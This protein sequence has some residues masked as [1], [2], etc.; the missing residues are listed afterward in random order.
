MARYLGIDLKIRLRT[1]A[2]AAIG[3]SRRLGIGKVRNLDT[4]LLWIQ[5]KVREGDV[6]VEKV[7]GQDNLADALTKYL[8]APVMSKHL[9][10]MGLA[11]EK[12]RP[13]SAP[14]LAD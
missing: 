13:E 1:D 10:A 2:T 8:E 3:M 12:G 11:F 6:V 4:S 5:I 7:A 14:V 9:M